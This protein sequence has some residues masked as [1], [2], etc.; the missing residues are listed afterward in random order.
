MSA[1]SGA[2]IETVAVTLSVSGGVWSWRLGTG[3]LTKTVESC[4]NSGPPGCELYPPQEHFSKLLGLNRNREA[5]SK[6]ASKYIIKTEP[7]P[8][9]N[10]CMLSEHGDAILTDCRMKS[11]QTEAAT[12]QNYSYKE[13]FVS[14]RKTAQ[15][16]RHVSAETNPDWFSLR[17]AYVPWNHNPSKCLTLVPWAQKKFHWQF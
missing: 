9:G 3:K 13:W 6:A 4:H 2:T 14:F 16:S 1:A 8:T 7:N 12:I 10:R 15:Q 5:A 17:K 11:N